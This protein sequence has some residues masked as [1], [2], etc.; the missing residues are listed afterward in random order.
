MGDVTNY[1]G[2]GVYYF[3]KNN[4]RWERGV[5]ITEYTY[6]PLELANI[7]N[8][9]LIENIHDHKDYLRN[10]E[11]T[12]GY[13]MLNLWGQSDNYPIVETYKPNSINTISLLEF[14]KRHI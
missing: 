13:R 5:G 12:G 10:G 9:T 6:T 11:N 8:L 3:D 14:R 7:R 2:D 4:W 1:S